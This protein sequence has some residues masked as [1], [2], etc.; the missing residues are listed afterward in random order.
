MKAA[1]PT[2]PQRESESDC[3]T[4]AQTRFQIKTR[5][6]WHPAAMASAAQLPPPRVGCSSSSSSSESQTP[7]SVREH[8]R[9]VTLDAVTAADGHTGIRKLTTARSRLSLAAIAWVGL[10]RGSSNQMSYVFNVLLRNAHGVDPL[11][12]CSKSQALVVL[13]P[14][15]PLHGPV[16]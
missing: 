14:A 11:T 15:R 8:C 13:S 3:F 1:E 6:C 5:Q 9:T 4:P 2:W 7:T 16:P 12:T 10:D